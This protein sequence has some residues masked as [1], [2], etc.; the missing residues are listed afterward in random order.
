ML[1][2]DYFE[3][4]KPRKVFDISK[5]EKGNIPLYDLGNKLNITKYINDWSYENK[6]NETLIL[7]T[8]DGNCYQPQHLKFAIMGHGMT[9]L[10]KLKNNLNNIDLNCKLITLQLNNIYSWSNPLRTIE[11]F[12]NI[13]LY[14][15]L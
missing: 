13:K 4:I 11:Q 12:K 14:L 5:I 7:I 8:F 10:L 1:L 15:Y 3:R 6:N 2:S 9:T